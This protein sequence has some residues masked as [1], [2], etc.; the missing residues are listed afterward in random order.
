MNRAACLTTP[1]EQPIT[2]NDN[3]E[4][5]GLGFDQ[6]IPISLRGS[7]SVIVRDSLS[8][9][10]ND[11]VSIG[12]TTPAGDALGGHNMEGVKYDERPQSGGRQNSDPTTAANRD[13]A[14]DRSPDLA[15]QRVD[16]PGRWKATFFWR[17]DPGLKALKAI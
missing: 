6:R 17:R 14:P 8:P 16:G 12:Q 5:T 3:N 15:P 11:P 10:E 9:G 2:I 7:E 4:Q 13:V 1:P